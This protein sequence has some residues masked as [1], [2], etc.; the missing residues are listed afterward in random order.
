[1]DGDIRIEC[2]NDIK[3]SSLLFFCLQSL[4][5]MLKSKLCACVYIGCS[6]DN[7]RKR[8]EITKLD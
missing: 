3:L 7:Y 6:R 1:M 4:L 5:S 8:L 2:G